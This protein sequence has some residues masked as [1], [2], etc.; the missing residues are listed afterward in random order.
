MPQLPAVALAS[1]SPASRHYAV[2]T[3]PIVVCFDMD[4]LKAVETYIAK[5]VSVPSA[6]K[7]LL[8]DSHTVCYEQYAAYA[9]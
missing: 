9:V 8:L 3:E 5:M 4:V 1:L 7:V 2:V 6:M